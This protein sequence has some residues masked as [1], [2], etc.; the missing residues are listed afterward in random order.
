MQTAH[1][2]VIIPVFNAAQ[3]LSQCLDSLLCQSYSDF[4][5]LLID[6]GSTDAS[7]AICHHYA[8]Q[9]KRIQVIHQPNKGVSAA[10]N[11]GLHRA[12]S[13]FITFVDADD[14]VDPNH[15][16][17]LIEGM[18]QCQSDC[19]ICGYWLE[20]PGKSERRCYCVSEVLSA[21]TAIV[22]MLMPNR[23][24]GFLC[25]K[26]FRRSVIQ[27][28]RIALQETLY[29]AEDMLFCATYFTCCQKVKC[30][31]SATYHYRQHGDSAI[32]KQKTS[33]G[34]L[35]RRTAVTALDAVLA[36]CQTKQARNLCRARRQTE[37]AEVCCRLVTEKSLLEKVLAL[38]K[39]LRQG[40]LCVL[41]SC[42][43]LKSKL[44][45]GC[46]V[47]C[48]TLFGRYFLYRQQRSL[49]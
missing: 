5:I 40:W 15:L 37:F 30:I 48:P 41:T 6:D 34:W 23:F 3:F 8:L 24:Q 39:E 47:L 18:E 9:D 1:I 27:N 25:N 26:L 4:E 19:S 38:Q 49:K 11:T 2:G 46:M 33:T 32:R 36:L 13:E 17:C 7:L 10:R 31:Q 21:D 45:H 22:S 44:K 16:K 28:N 35:E 43:P 42:L 20:Y 12:C 14:W 29:Y